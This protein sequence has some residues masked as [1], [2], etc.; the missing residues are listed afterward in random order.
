M[1]NRHL[2]VGVAVAATVLSANDSAHAQPSTSPRCNDQLIRGTYGFVVEGERLTGPPP[3]GPLKGVAMT[4]FDGKGGLTQIDSISLNGMAAADFSP[5][6]TGSYSV[7][8]DC[9]GSFSL[10]FTDGRPA[11]TVNFVVANNG[12]E[13]DTVVVGT[14]FP[15]SSPPCTGQGAVSIRSTGT[16]RFLGQD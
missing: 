16:K 15:P 11:A 4:T 1:K 6:A 12:L 2:L 10:V 3:L 9:T 5:P 14:C 13:I 7:N 8:Q